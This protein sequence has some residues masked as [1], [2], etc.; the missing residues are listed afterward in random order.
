[1]KKGYS[2]SIRVI[3]DASPIIYFAKMG[4]LDLLVQV[5]GIVGVPPAV[6]REAVEVG[7]QHGRPDASRMAQSLAR[8]D[9]AH[10]TLTDQESQLSQSLQ[11]RDNLGPGESETI[12]CAYHRN[13]IALL[14]DKRAR[15]VA[16]DYQVATRQAV[17]VLFLSLLRRFK[18]PSEFAELLRRLA[19]LTGM[20]A[21]TLVEREALAAEIAKQLAG[22]GG[23]NHE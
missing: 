9:L 6:H 17:D 14:H 19:V 11:A 20:D 15:R 21:A 18:T 4:Q 3:S 13:A 22:Y 12:A 1:V 8:G 23:D 7:Q 2:M 5:M 10:V 16:G